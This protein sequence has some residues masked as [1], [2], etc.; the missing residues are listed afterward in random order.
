MENRS[1]VVKIMIILGVLAPAFYAFTEKNTLTSFIGF[2]L[3]LVNIFLFRLYYIE[4]KDKKKNRIV[5]LDSALLQLLERNEEFKQLL[6]DGKK[7]KAIKKCRSLTGCDL[8]TAQEYVS[9][10]I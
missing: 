10:I 9:S 1:T 8:L 3:F 4:Y 5:Q 7:Y 2:L 6:F